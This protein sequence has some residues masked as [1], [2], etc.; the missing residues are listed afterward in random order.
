MIAKLSDR[1]YRG[2]FVESQINI[3]IPFQIRALRK[4]RNW[5]QPELADRA[6][7]KQSRISAIEK[8]GGPKLNIDTLCRLASAFD[9]ALD[10]RFVPFG[11]LVQRSDGFDPDSFSVKSFPEELAEDALAE[12]NKAQQ[13]E[14]IAAAKFPQWLVNAWAARPTVP[15]SPRSTQFF[16]NMQIAHDRWGEFAKNAPSVA[17]YLDAAQ[18]EAVTAIQ[19]TYPAIEQDAQSQTVETE[20]A[21]PLVLVQDSFPFLRPAQWA[22]HSDRG[23]ENRPAGR[24]GRRRPVRGQNLKKRN[25]SVRASR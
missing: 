7:M 9:V 6:G 17:T 14:Q 8:P 18:A 4:Q 12:Q 15:L 16:V 19:H 11:E 23:L 25:A 3:G 13:S 21:S 24:V 1:E 10:V 20:N 22:A 5:T 2:S